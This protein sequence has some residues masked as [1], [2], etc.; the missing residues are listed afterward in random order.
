MVEG[1]DLR[2]AR[3]RKRLDIF[4]VAR[5]CGID[6]VSYSALETGALKADDALAQEILDII[7]RMPARSTGG[8]IWRRVVA[9]I[10]R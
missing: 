5:R 6:P 1:R 4:S 10:K 7:A 2:E 3:Q 8:Q 9:W